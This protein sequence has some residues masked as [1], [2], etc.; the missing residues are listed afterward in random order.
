MVL[1]HLKK[2]EESLL[3]WETPAQTPISE[4][5]GSL[6]TTYNFKLRI[7]RLVSAVKDLLEYGPLKPDSEQG[8]SEEQIEE[9]SH[10]TA[11]D[12]KP[13]I[14]DGF[15]FFEVT[16]PTGR[17]VGEACG[18]E[19]CAIINKTLVEAEAL[20]SKVHTS[21]TRNVQLLVVC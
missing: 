20:V 2:G 16:D 7:Q 19:G 18:D 14:R 6:V 9:L 17:R 10:S 4:L 8:Y 21:Q 12:R 3:F 13:F 15:E 5:V 11:V 1:I